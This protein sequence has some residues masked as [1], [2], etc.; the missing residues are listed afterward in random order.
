MAAPGRERMVVAL[1][2]GPVGHG[3]I[4]VDLP[5][6]G[7]A[8]RIACGDGPAGRPWT[9]SLFDRAGAPHGGGG[10]HPATQG[11]GPAGPASPRRRPSMTAIDDRTAPIAPTLDELREQLRIPRLRVAVYEPELNEPCGS[12]GHWEHVGE[13]ATAPVGTLVKAVR[14]DPEAMRAA[15]RVVASMV[16]V[17]DRRRP[18]LHIRHLAAARVLRYLTAVP[19]TAGGVRGGARLL[20]VRTAQPREGAI[21]AAAVLRLHNRHRALAASFILAEADRWVCD[22]VRIL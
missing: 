13:R 19:C 1:R 20:S 10:Q 3:V 5:V 21:E 11:V 9:A 17:L 8:L 7:A 18:P 6:K 16:E 2:A 15:A 4:T 12:C 22:T 14:P